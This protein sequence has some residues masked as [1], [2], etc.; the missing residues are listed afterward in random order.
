MH[1]DATQN[2]RNPVHDAVKEENVS[3]MAP[4]N[5]WICQAEQSIQRVCGLIEFKQVRDREK[6][7]VEFKAHFKTL[8][9]ETLSTRCR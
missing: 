8:L 5:S 4:D 9:P 1:L 3:R 6:H 2:A 7:P